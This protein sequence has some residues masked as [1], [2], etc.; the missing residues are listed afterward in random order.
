[1]KQMLVIL[2][3]GYK[4]SFVKKTICIKTMNYKKNTIIIPFYK[5]ESK[6]IANFSN[7]LN[8]IDGNV[9]IN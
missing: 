8:L 5:M 1:M 4:F 3:G 7:D 9:S 6:N 2:N